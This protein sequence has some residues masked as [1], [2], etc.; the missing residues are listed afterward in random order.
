LGAIPV[1]PLLAGTA[2]VATSLIGWSV[3]VDASGLHRVGD[4]AELILISAI[5]GGVS[6][7]VATWL[8]TN[9]APALVAG[10]PI[11]MLPASFTASAYCT[12]AFCPDFRG[13]AKRA[14]AAI[15]SSTGVSYSSCCPF[16]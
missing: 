2:L 1:A 15:R 8:V 7:A 10:A 12:N 4:D 13:A 3:D 6:D 5:A 14:R 9:K 11:G 16:G